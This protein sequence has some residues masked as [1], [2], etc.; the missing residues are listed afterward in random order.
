VAG[1]RVRGNGASEPQDG[2]QG[3]DECEWSSALYARL[4]SGTLKHLWLL[5]VVQRR[6]CGAVLLGL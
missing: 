6:V 3:E 2:E 1:G 5:S 4:Q